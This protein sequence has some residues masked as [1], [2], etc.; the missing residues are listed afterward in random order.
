MRQ[1]L[2][3]DQ[4]GYYTASRSKDGSNPVEQF[5]T[6]GDFITSPEISQ[7]F[8]E[9]V[10]IWFV[11][12]WLAQIQ[13]RRK[14]GAGGKTCLV[15]LGPGRGTLMD[16]ILRTIRNFKPMARSLEAVYLVEA[17]E[18]LRFKQHKMLCGEEAEI[19]KTSEGWKSMSKKYFDTPVVWVEDVAL[20][21]K[22]ETEGGGM[23]L[24]IA[25]EFFDA[26]PIHAFESVA[27]APES[28]KEPRAELL[29]KA[30]R[31]MVRPSSASKVPQWREY[32][33]APSKKK[34]TISTPTGPIRA[35]PGDQ[36]DFQ[37]TLAKASTPSSLV[38]PETAPRYRA[39]KS[40]PGSSI[41]I[42]PESNRYISEFAKRIGGNSTTTRPT[43]TPEIQTLNT[44]SGAAS[45]TQ[46]HQK[47]LPAGAALIIDYGP[48]DT[49][50]INSLRGIRAHKRVSPFTSPGEID[51]SA[52]VD[53]TALAE[54]AL[55]A[56]EG[57]EVYGPVEQGAWLHQMGGTTRV[58]QLVNKAG[59]EE[60][61]KD[62]LTGW[63]RLVE[64][65][66][67][68][69][70]GEIYKVMAI[71]PES[72]GKRRPVGFGGDVQT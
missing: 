37:L 32:L 56:S 62:M 5:G 28:E 43:G 3:S 66:G 30:G 41:E 59:S 63:K 11:S 39:L 33:V 9:L 42:S 27:A 36:E 16:D 65:S 51:I 61:K 34:S 20:L 23:P 69:G 70:M 47:P 7:V 53:F 64:G 15:E 17:S 14:M 60:R 48:L 71:V 13:G 19:E 49:I 58:E 12:E 67:L 29:D 55:T 2:T 25:H 50:P 44:M 6:K 4:G 72:G 26:L 68:G 45:R 1:C 21:P 57:V 24:L 46:L 35:Q 52:D 38:L 18:A 10:G 22:S 40:R 54:A 8:G 31:P